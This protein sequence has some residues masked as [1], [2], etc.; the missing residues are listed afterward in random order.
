[1]ISVVTA[2]NQTEQSVEEN[3]MQICAVQVSEILQNQIEKMCELAVEYLR[4]NY[5]GEIA[6]LKTEIAQLS[7]SQKFI[8]AQYDEMKKEN[9]NLKKAN[10]EQ[11]KATANSAK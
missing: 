11:K 8:S 5:E 7:E 2:V 3:F 1:M 4:K 6:S 10:S 9:Q